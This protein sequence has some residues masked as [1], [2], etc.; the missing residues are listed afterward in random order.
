ML[1]LIIYYFCLASF[2]LAIETSEIYD[3][4]WALV[5]YGNKDSTKT[6]LNQFENVEYY[7]E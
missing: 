5:V 2:A 3:N 7:Q 1:K 6:F 4:S